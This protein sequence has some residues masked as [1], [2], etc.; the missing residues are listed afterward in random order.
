MFENLFD[1]K[2]FDLKVNE[3]FN[4]IRPKFIMSWDE[5]KFEFILINY[6]FTYLYACLLIIKILKLSGIVFEFENLHQLKSSA[7]QS[8]RV[9]FKGQMKLINELKAILFIGHPV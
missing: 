7:E 4:V 2:I 3:I 1:E 8:I 6:L 9:Q 5:V